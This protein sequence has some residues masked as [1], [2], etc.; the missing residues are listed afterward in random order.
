MDNQT[1]RQNKNL[2]TIIHHQVSISRLE[3]VVATVIMMGQGY[4]FLSSTSIFEEFLRVNHGFDPD[5]IGAVMVVLAGFSLAL[6]IVSILRRG[7]EIW[8]PVIVLVSLSPSIIL[9]SISLQGFIFQALTPIIFITWLGVGVF[10]V[11]TVLSA[12][13]AFLAKEYMEDVQ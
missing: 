1:N 5:R 9:G 10:C 13:V 3:M 12:S 11:T 7:P 2:A 6:Q 4:A 8:V